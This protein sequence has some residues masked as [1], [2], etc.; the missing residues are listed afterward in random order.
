MVEGGPVYSVQRLVRSRR[1][2][3]GIQYLVDWEGC[4]PEARQWVPASFIVDPQLVKGFHRE[5]PDQPCLP[6]SAVPISQQSRSRPPSTPLSEEQADNQ[7][8]QGKVDLMDTE[9]SLTEETGS[10]PATP[11]S[12]GS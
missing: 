11:P 2:G 7:E 9:D 6:S 5:N 1:R 10:F 3:R 4:G 12:T 8:V